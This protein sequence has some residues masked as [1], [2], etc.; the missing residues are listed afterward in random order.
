MLGRLLQ[1]D[2]ARSISFQSIWG[3]GDTFAFTTEAGTVVD[4]KTAL[5][6][7]AFYACVL[8]ISD[9]ISTLPVD[10][11]FR[12]QGNRRP[13][14]PKPEWVDRPDVELLRTEHYQQLLVSL[15]MDGNSFTRIFRDGRGDIA[16]LIVLDPTK[17]EILRSKE[18][19]LVYR[20]DGGIGGDIPSRDMLHVTEIKRPGYL[21]GVSRVNELKDS[22]G[23]SAALQSFASRFFGQGAVTSGVIEVPG[24]LTSEQ[25]KNLVDS[26]ESKHSGYRKSHRPGLLS[27]GAK[28]VK[29]GV[30]PDEAQMLESRKLAI[31]EMARIFRV[32]P[33]M[34]GVTTPGAMSYSSVEQN[35]I[36]FVIHTLRPYLVKIEDAYSRLLPGGA[37]LKFNVDGLL[38]GDFATRVQGYSTG[39]QAGF[40]SVDDVRRLEDLSPVDGGEV[41]RVPLANIDLSA[42]NLAET[43]I[44]VDMAERLVKSG[45]EP[46]S[47]LAALGL[48]TISHTGLPSAQLQQV[49]NLD[50]AAPQSVY[51]VNTRGGDVN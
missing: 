40:Y 20:Y 27:A 50:P 33:A 35:S 49:Q 15:L 31:E 37:F 28:Y 9:T 4:E 51:E 19:E 3:A 26:F 45:F 44:K 34:I 22:I 11:F 10:C 38:R 36:N 39:L 46:S 8:L 43:Q 29:T 12:E 24:A 5:R 16:N 14:R 23:L 7:S 32:P 17:V 18:G 30:N 41:Y 48:P 2:E 1:T 21:R 6:V 13:F 25:A 47:V 42:A